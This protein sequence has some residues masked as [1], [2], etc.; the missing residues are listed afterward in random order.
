MENI[1][2]HSVGSAMEVK[3]IIE[4]LE[5]ILGEKVYLKKVGLTAVMYFG[6]DSVPSHCDKKTGIGIS[7]A[8]K[9]EMLFCCLDSSA[10]GPVNLYNKQGKLYPLR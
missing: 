6:R 8:D 2:T 10:A 9:R 7:V 5:K 3:E 1:D 4:H